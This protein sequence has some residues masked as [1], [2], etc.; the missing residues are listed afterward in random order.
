VGFS[1]VLNNV[2]EKMTDVEMGEA[3]KTLKSRLLK[4]LKFI[5]PA[6]TLVATVIGGYMVFKK[7][8]IR[9]DEDVE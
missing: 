8:E 7:E 4:G 5:M 3:F 9:L 1:R 2:Y 6:I